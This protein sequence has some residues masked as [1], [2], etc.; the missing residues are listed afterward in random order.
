MTVTHE[1]NDTSMNSNF[2]MVYRKLNSILKQGGK[3]V[4]VSE[5][6]SGVKIVIDGETLLSGEFEKGEAA[7]FVNSEIFALVREA[8][9]TGNLRYMEDA[10]G[11]KYLM[12]PY[13]PS[14]RLIVFGAGHIA[15]PLAEF[16]AKTGFLVTVIDD[17]PSF[18]NIGRFPEA[19]NVICES[20]DKCFDQIKLNMSA[21]AVIVT[22]GH[23]HD[24]DCLRQV[25]KY[26]TAYTGMIGSKRRV[27][28]VREHL[29][30]EGYDPQKVASVNA[31]IGLDIGAVTPEEIAISIIAQVIS[32]K[33]LVRTSQED[34]TAIKVNWADYDPEVLEELG[35]DKDDP[36]ALITIIST[37]GSV[38]R[39][40]GAKMLVWPD[41]RTKGT[42]G[43]GCSEGAIIRTAID[44]IR[45]GGC[46]QEEIDMTGDVAED[47][48]MVCGGTMQ[49]VIER[50]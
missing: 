27:R 37:K 30:A 29:L 26:N 2:C 15:K 33:R 5:L 47:E 42:I 18:A 17:R 8:L 39:E 1:R 45:N 20:F 44:I 35:N 6:K 19:E 4:V 10:E 23:R 25:L 13:F 22:R 12:E 11:C 16:G 3:A 31:P 48:G 14:P 38:P 21:F 40:A 28:G 32:F 34:N 24:I 43:G 9:I 41:G 46:I 49:V 7:A 36:K 50:V